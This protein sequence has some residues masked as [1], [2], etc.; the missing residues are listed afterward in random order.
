MLLRALVY[1]VLVGVLA[2]PVMGDPKLDL[3]KADKD[4]LMALGLSPS[5]ALQI[6][7]HREK[8]GPFLQVEELVAVQQMN[9]Q[10]YEKIK[11]RVM[12]E[13]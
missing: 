8:S 11:E 4:E 13:E 7:S 6:I 1:V 5:Q 12:V 10:T 2:V 3:N 9:K